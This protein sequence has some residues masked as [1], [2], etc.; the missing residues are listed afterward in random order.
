MTQTAVEL[1]TG[2]AGP[3]ANGAVLGAVCHCKK[4][5]QHPDYN[6]QLHMTSPHIVLESSHSAIQN[7][8]RSDT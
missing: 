2:R 5:R 3:L 1:W 7:R 8:E 6:S 4:C